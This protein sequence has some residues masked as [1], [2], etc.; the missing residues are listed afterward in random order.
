MT[1]PRNTNHGTGICAVCREEKSLTANL[2]IRS[3][4][5]NKV[6]CAGGSDLPY[7]PAKDAE[8]LSGFGGDAD[9]TSRVH[10]NDDVFGNDPFG[11]D[12]TTDL[13][14]EATWT[15]EVDDRP[16]LF[17]VRNAEKVLAAPDVPPE[18][19]DEAHRILSIYT[20]EGVKGGERQ[21]TF[22]M[23]PEM[24]QR[25]D[26]F[27]FTPPADHVHRF[28]YVDD[29]NGHSGSFCSCG[30][31][32]VAIPAKPAHGGPNPH[33]APLS[34]GHLA[35]VPDVPPEAPAA[36]P[37]A[38]SDPKEGKDQGPGPWFPSR[39]DGSCDTCGADFGEGEE[40]R[41][42]GSGGWEAFECCGDRDDT[43][44]E[45]PARPKVVYPK[46]PVVSGRY[47]AP[48]PV[49][50]KK[51]S[52]TRVTNF[53]KKASDHFALEQW[54][55][56]SLAV[57]LFSRPDL[58]QQVDGKDVKADRTFLNRLV[59]EA[60]QAAGSKDR[61]RLGT[62][63]HKHTEEVD[64]GHKD[65]ADVP[66][67]F[68]DDVAIYL[69]AMKVKGLMML[70]HL[71]ERS[72]AVVDLEV[73]G[74]FDGIVRLPDGT[75]AV[76]DKKTGATLEFNQAEIAV[77]IAVYAHGVNSAGVATAHPSNVEGEPPTWTWEK[78]RDEDGNVIKV[79]EDIGIVI[80]IPYGTGDCF[81]YSIPLDVGWRGAQL[82][83]EV[84]SWQKVKNIVEAV[85]D[86]KPSGIIAELEKATA[87]PATDVFTEAEKG[88]EVPTAANTGRTPVL[89][90]MEKFAAVTTKEEA[91]DVYRQA[92]SA[93]VG[94][95][96][97]KAGVEVGKGALQALAKKKAEELAKRPPAPVN[98]E[99]TWEDHFAEVTSKEEA[100]RLYRGAKAA[101]LPSGRLVELAEI[102]RSALQALKEAAT[103]PAQAP[104]L[105]WE[106]RFMLIT[107]K[108]QAQE[109]YREAKDQVSP[110]RLADLVNRGKLALA[111][112][113]GPKLPDPEPKPAAVQ[114]PP[115]WEDRFSSVLSKDEASKLFALA[116]KEVAT[117]G[118]TRLNA[119]VKLAQVQ[120]SYLEEPP[121]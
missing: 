91:L 98:P 46:L 16:T 30:A 23:L 71:M 35:S 78:P 104:E 73:I 49:T 28:A 83:R 117:L 33:R 15:M 67:Q 76:G 9:R 21:D 27:A 89:D 38:F 52:W 36:V 72:T 17:E 18:V 53:V 105:T 57:G 22:T 82:C 43:D 110:E 115:T 59:E 31:E 55:N 5:I 6:P 77:Q 19:L 118:M 70:P 92:Q 116:R 42:D 62:I 111:Q 69:A 10:P 61:A 88:F 103:F 54:G 96:V 120:L 26:T 58:L 50:G 66:E 8:V 34:R 4:R 63:M 84:Q 11:D 2:R 1:A 102:G 119:L 39:Y 48:H 56:R 45:R 20:A 99:P 95:V 85:P 65:L 108:D 93:G 60:K 79:R 32:E 29:G 13:P 97:L 100:G 68:R 107:S 47:K 109:L 25:D 121:F 7:D 74:T 114:A 80:H 41:A 75:Y 112:N 3:H 113:T 37:D 101:G 51:S 44:S 64:A 24:G 12:A 90:W 86:A 81:I 40:I 14:A 106:D 94:P 87:A